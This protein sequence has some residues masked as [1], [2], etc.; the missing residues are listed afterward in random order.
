MNKLRGPSKGPR[1]RSRP[2]ASHCQVA[3]KYEGSLTTPNFR[4]T[5]STHVTPKQ[6][7]LSFL[8]RP[9]L[10]CHQL[11]Q[12]AGTVQASTGGIRTETLRNCFNPRVHRAVD[13]LPYISR[14]PRKA[15]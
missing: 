7:A 12:V 4:R 2:K 8:A 13:Q 9:R 15:A 6:N 10:A 1:R 14:D 3:Q 5:K 11:A